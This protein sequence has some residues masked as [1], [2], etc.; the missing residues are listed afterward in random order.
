M[1]AVLE[2]IFHIAYLIAVFASGIWIIRNSNGIKM[3]RLYGL[4]AIILAGG[5]A[6]HLIP[7]IYALLTTGFDSIPEALGLGKLVTSVTMTVF[8]LILYNI[9]LIHYE[10]TPKKVLGGINYGLAIIRIALC[11]FPQ[12]KWLINDTSSVWG[13][14]RNIP[15]IIL[16]AII[17]F[18]FFAKAKQQKDKGLPFMWVAILLSFVFYIPV[19]L[20]AGSTPIVGI[21]M[22]PKSVMYVWIVLMGIFELKARITDT[23]V[24]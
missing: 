2:P 4:M 18:L 13:I 1:Q 24:A 8:Y 14:Y 21:L 12:N 16:G 7:R 17:I 23:T 3:F 6:F 19:V 20:F 22:L 5:D 11:C 15:F 9:W 10:V